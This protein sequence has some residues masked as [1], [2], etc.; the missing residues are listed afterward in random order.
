MIV[1]CFPAVKDTSLDKSVLF[2]EMN[3]LDALVIVFSTKF[4]FFQVGNDDL[5][6]EE[7]SCQFD[8]LAAITFATLCI[9]NGKVCNVGIF[10]TVNSAIKPT[11]CSSSRK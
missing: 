6:W 3:A 9:I 11:N 7:S 2:V 10:P 4:R 5:A 8:G 1:F